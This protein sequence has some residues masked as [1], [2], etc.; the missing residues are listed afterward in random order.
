MLVVDTVGEDL[1]R[2]VNAALLLLDENMGQEP[3]N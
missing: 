2:F 3:K 1:A